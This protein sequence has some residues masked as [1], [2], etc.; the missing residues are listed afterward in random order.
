MPSRSLSR[1]RRRSQDAEAAGFQPVGSAASTS[2]TASNPPNIYYLHHRLVGE[3]A[4]FGP[5]LDRAL[6]LGFDTVLL[7]PIFAVGATGDVFQ[8]LNH[9]LA[10]PTLGPNLSA[11][12]ALGAIASACR[13]RGLRLFMDLSLHQ[14]DAQHPLVTANPHAFWIRRGNGEDAPIDPRHPGPANG[15]ARARLHDPASA[16]IVAAWAV[17]EIGAWTGEGISGFRVVHAGEAP[18]AFWRR[19]IA[20]VRAGSSPLVFIAETSGLSR[21]ADAALAA[22]GFDAVT[23]SPPGDGRWTSLVEDYEAVRLAAAVISAVETPFG[24]RASAGELVSERA[25]AVKRRLSLAAAAGAGL[26]IPMGFE[27]AVRDPLDPKAGDPQTFTAVSGRGLSEEVVHAIRRANQRAGELAPYVGEMRRLGGGGRLATALLRG[28][29]PDLRIATRALLAL[30]NPNLN[31]SLGLNRAGLL[32]GVEFSVFQDIDSLGEPFRDLEPGEVRLLVAERNRPI[33]GLMADDETAAVAQTA[34]AAAEGPRVVIEAI[35]PRVE[36]GDFPVK[37]AVGGTVTVEADIYADGHEALA[38]EVQWRALDDQAWSASRLAPLE[39]DRWRG[40]FPVERIGRYEYRVAAWL[41]RFGGFRRDFQKKLDAGVAAP[42]DV[43]EGCNLIAAA[44]EAADGELQAGLQALAAALKSAKAPKRQSLLMA[45]ET[46]ALMERADNQPHRLASQR[47]WVDAE[48]LSA[49]FASWYELFPR[50][51]TPDP[52]RHGSFADVVERLP[53]I[54]AMGFDVLY[55]PP[56]HPIGRKNRKGP[57]NSLNAGP[58][59]PGSPYAIGADEGGHDAIHPDLGSFADFQMLVAAAAEQGLEIALDFAIQCSP[60]HPWLKQH[61]DWFAW[62]PDGSIKYAEN[63]PK[64]YQDIVNVDFYAPGAAPALWTA[65]RDVVLLWIRHGV[66][67]FRVDN[68]HTK[69][70]PFWDWMIGEVRGRHPE[71][72][73]LAE[74]FT[75]PKPMYRLAKAGFSQSYSYFTWRHSKAEFIDYMTELTTGPAKEFFRPN[76]FVNTPDIN[77]YFLQTSGRPGFLI[78]AALAATL[79]GLW[80]VYSGFELLE[81]EPLPG[82]EEYANSEKYEIRPRN[83]SAPGNIIAQITRLNRIRKDNPAL[84]THLGVTFQ[85]AWNDNVLFFAKSA[86]GSGDMVLVAINLDPGN[87]QTAD[88]EV[89][90]WSFGLPDDGAL[91]VEDLVHDSRFVWHG[92]RQTVW[93]GLDLPYAIWRIQP[94]R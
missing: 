13:A 38:A 49:Q 27:F 10:A 34:T 81:A 32:A 87:A 46:T 83:W 86:P 41:D 61:P 19:L 70:L 85:T 48:R 84:Q 65:L 29:A 72:I 33:S 58:Q 14:F 3:V 25:A 36:G 39:N 91:Q 11:T 31:R 94:E 35:S 23:L 16:A 7:S 20:E 78:R 52:S 47:Q 71:V 63:P 88:L 68:P 28:D 2:P 76:F 40:A 50:S 43:Q 30:I 73:F 18:P 92:K 59:D 89:P 80:G 4:A 1:P 12:Q 44:A 24:P 5:H 56:I 64:K 67:T 82:R 8:P 79:S 69:P 15:E 26:L 57:N 66:K 75:R 22:S 93:L 53:A 74:A 45:P 60:D 77:P 42:V 55:F 21:D 9:S 37:R 51:Q 62:R 17:G 6:A 90:L 54:R